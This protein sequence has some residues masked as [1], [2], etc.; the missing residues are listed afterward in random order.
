MRNFLQRAALAAVL[1]VAAGVADAR[2]FRV[3]HAEALGLRAAQLDANLAA[4]VQFQAYGKQFTLELRSNSRLL[5]NL[6]AAQKAQLQ[7]FP[8]YKGAIA[9]VSGSWV[10]LT[11]VGD[12]LQGAFWDGEDL[13]TIAPARD[14]E[15]YALQS[16]G[17]AGDEL[18]V[19]RLSDTQSVLDTAYC[20]TG[21]QQDVA[22]KARSSNQDGAYQKLIAELRQQAVTA[23]VATEQIEIAFVADFE[24][25]QRYGADTQA[26][27]LARAN[28]LDGIFGNQVGVSIIPF[29][30]IFTD[31][32]DPFTSTNASTLLNELS[33]YRRNTANIRSRGLAHLMTGRGL[34]GSTAGIAYVGALCSTGSGAGLSE[35]TGSTT[36]A[37]LVAAHEIG[38]NFGAP[39]DGEAGSACESAGST[40][41]MAPQINGSSTFSSCSLDQIRPVVNSAACVTAIPTGDVALSGLTGTLSAQA[42][43]DFNVVIDVNSVGAATVNGVTLTATPGATLTVTSATTTSG[44]C[45]V[46]ANS[47]VS[48]DL[49]SMASSATRRITMVTRGSA[50]GSTDVDVTLAA[51]N[52]SN[53]A[54]NTGSQAVTISAAPVQ[55]PPPPSDDGDSGGGA[56]TAW[57]L[58]LLAA[59]W[60]L[61]RRSDLARLLKP[62]SL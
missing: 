52:D 7:N 21:D 42:N 62:L 12:A 4:P 45:N 46:G 6:P 11:K 48:C 2:E 29:F 38:H 25:S 49:G 32:A 54:N 28:V 36:I 15:P 51:A 19:Y 1:V 26:T 35:S 43:A 50:A 22:G 37:S 10:R 58:F 31:A 40:F 16:L 61:Q 23:A 30:Q 53:S 5:A 3:L 60:V 24:M 27:M 55:P 39:H 9:G 57:L 17:V 13:Y 34:D 33:T 14:V 20:A 18:V 44:S 56:L 47:V 59:A 41:L 8:I